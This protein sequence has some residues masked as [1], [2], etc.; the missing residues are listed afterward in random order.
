MFEKKL[1]RIGFF[2]SLATM[3][4]KMGIVKPNK[5]YH[6]HSIWCLNIA[7]FCGVINDNLFKYLIVFL[8]IDLKG[9]TSSSAILS[10]VGIVYVLPFLLFSMAAGV[11]A[12]RFSKQ[13]MIIL[14]KVTEVLIMLLGALALF[15]QSDLASYSLMFLLSMQSA[16]FGP[17]KYSIIPELVPKEKISKANGI[18]TSFTYFGIIM[19]TFLATSLSQASGKN[20]TL[21]AIIGVGIAII[22]LAFSL[23]IPHT[24]P[25]SSTEKI[26]PFFVIE[27]FNNLKLAS[28]TPF[29]LTTIFGSASFLFIGAYFQL[30]IIPYAMDSLGFSQEAGGHLFL[31]TS[32]GI[33]VGSALA[34]KM[35]RDRP[36]L[37]MAT[38]SGVGLSIL[39]MSLFFFDGLFIPI[40]IAILGIGLLGGIYIVPFDSFIQRYSPENKRGQVVAAS[41]F[42]SFCGVLVAPILLYVFTD[43]LGYSPAQ[44]FLIMGVLILFSVGI[45]IMSLRG[46]FFST[47]SKLFI[48]PFYNLVLDDVPVEKGTT[49]VMTV[50]KM[51]KLYL[52][53][54]ATYNPRMEFFFPKSKKKYLDVFLNWFSPIQ[55]LY[56]RKKHPNIMDLFQKKAKKAIWSK[57]VPYLVIPNE[58]DD[59]YQY[60]KKDLY[61][62]KKM[63]PCRF[64]AMHVEV[65]PR[66]DQLD[67][68]HLKRTRIHM[69][70]NLH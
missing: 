61:T 70:F 49:Y 44:G 18:I 14:L 67:K 48:K 25:K 8:F 54:L 55:Y 29:L 59:K 65:T 56:V 62:L 3:L 9:A 53:L 43:I 23:F 69:R 28:K 50:P 22:G 16:F 37:G 35:C 68:K 17:P 31:S 24:E 36:E 10:I 64:I 51:S 39:L 34:G 66:H 26:N 47:F 46:F 20:Y 1:H 63:K 11:L 2:Q 7:Q 19:G 57:R 4:E 32:I 42:L 45:M 60:S 38:L 15:F 30:N 13:R 6:R 52:F 27:I 41:N 33:A 58:P 5:V 40:F 12:D 21:V